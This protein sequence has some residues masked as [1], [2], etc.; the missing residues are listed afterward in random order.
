MNI[1][2]C[3]I[4]G[5]VAQWLKF[6]TVAHRTVLQVLLVNGKKLYYTLSNIVV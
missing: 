2:E 4:K 1:L 3:K 5:H 6:S